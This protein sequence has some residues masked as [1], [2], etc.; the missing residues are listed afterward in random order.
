[1]LIALVGTAVLLFPN[2]VLAPDAK[3]VEI[4]QSH[5]SRFRCYTLDHFI[6]FIRRTICFSRSIY[7]YSRDLFAGPPSRF[8]YRSESITGSNPVYPIVEMYDRWGIC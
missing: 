4:I 3:G 1:M 6:G 5:V 2:R 8:V 7:S